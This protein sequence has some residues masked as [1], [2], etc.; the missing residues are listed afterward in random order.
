MS[1]NSK[2]SKSQFSKICIYSLISLRY[3]FKAPNIAASLVYPPGA[4]AQDGTP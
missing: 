3:M 1:N 2:L 4:W